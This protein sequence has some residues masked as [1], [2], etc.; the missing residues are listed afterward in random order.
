MFQ[1]LFGNHFDLS[2]NKMFG[3]QFMHQIQTNLRI[4]FQFEV[5]GLKNKDFFF[6]DNYFLS[7][8]QYTNWFFGVDENHIIDLFFLG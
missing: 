5:L 3:S 8:N 2:I 4:V 6:H 7:S 1:N